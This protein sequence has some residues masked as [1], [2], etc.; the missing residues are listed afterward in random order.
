LIHE[1]WEW[2]V[3]PSPEQASLTQA[4]V[5]ERLGAS[6]QEWLHTPNGEL[7]RGKTPAYMIQR[8]RLR[9]PMGSEGADLMV[10]C[11]CPL[12]QMIADSGP[13]FWH[14]DGC[15]MDDEFPFEMFAGTRE[16]WKEK[17][18]SWAEWNAQWEREQQELAAVGEND[19]APR[20]D[21]EPVEESSP[22]WQRSFGYR[23]AS[24]S[25]EVTVFGIGAHLAELI[26][27][28]RQTGGSQDWIETLNGDF[29]NLRA[30]VADP[31]SSLVEPVVEKFTEHLAAVSDLQPDLSAKCQDLE[32]QLHDFARR[33]SGEA[34][35]DDEF[36]F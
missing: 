26:V 6:Q 3:E 15:N 13:C 1:C 24:D 33:L 11:D 27:D 35:A 18:R 23:R 5:A 19:V 16:E 7:C 17:Q 22:V 9:L 2:V 14:L 34:D 4:E 25:P 8:E 32:R 28:L 30:A 29:G 31:S 12:C 36:P 10:D 20:L 21:E